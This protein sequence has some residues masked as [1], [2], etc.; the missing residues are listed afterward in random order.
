LRIAN[1][2]LPIEFFVRPS[3]FGMRRLATG[4]IRGGEPDAVLEG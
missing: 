4:R 2:K 1:C 3:R